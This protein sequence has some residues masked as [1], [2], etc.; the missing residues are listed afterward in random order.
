MNLFLLLAS[1]FTVEATTVLVSPE[2]EQCMWDQAAQGDLIVHRFDILKQDSYS[3]VNV[4]IFGPTEEEIILLRDSEGDVVSFVAEAEG[5]YSWCY[6][7][8]GS[9]RII[10]TF[11]NAVG[12]DNVYK[13]AAGGKVD[14]DTISNEI[15]HLQSNSDTLYQSALTYKIRLK[16]H[17][18]HSSDSLKTQTTFSLL[19]LCVFAF[20]AISGVYS[21]RLLF[22]TKRRI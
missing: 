2:D 1:L 21:V 6:E 12:K 14:V 20:A 16:Y 8:K 19:K 15:V 18:V 9:T 5:R 3:V 13:A 22:E 10:V 17:K 11:K 4:R 7:N